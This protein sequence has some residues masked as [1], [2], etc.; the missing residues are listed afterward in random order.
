MHES[1]GEW[2]ENWSKEVTD[3]WKCVVANIQYMLKPDNSLNTPTS[4]LFS[5]NEKPMVHT[6]AHLPV[7]KVERLI[8]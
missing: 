2:F 1:I 7:G 4:L 8:G 3:N 6:L 5:L